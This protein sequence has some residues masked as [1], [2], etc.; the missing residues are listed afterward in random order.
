VLQSA[1]T[2]ILLEVPDDTKRGSEAVEPTGWHILNSTNPFI[3]LY[4]SNGVDAVSEQ[5]REEGRTRNEEVKILCS[6]DT[7]RVRHQPF[8]LC[9]DRVRLL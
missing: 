5:K 3:T 4:G 9:N 2:E 7:D 8:N 6:S 1:P